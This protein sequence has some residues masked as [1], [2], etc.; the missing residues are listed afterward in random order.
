MYV[1][2]AV[3]VAAKSNFEVCCELLQVPFFDRL[4]VASYYNSANQK[5]KKQSNKKQKKVP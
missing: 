4:Q 5:T 3:V 1:I 2:A